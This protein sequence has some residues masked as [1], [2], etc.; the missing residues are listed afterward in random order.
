MEWIMR[1]QWFILIFFSLLFVLFLPYLSSGKITDM[2]VEKEEGPVDIEADELSYE[3]EKLIYEA[4]GKVEVKRGDL[5]LR[6]DHAQLNM[7]TKD[8]VAWGN[9]VLREGE[10]VLEAERLEINLDTRLGKVYQARLFLKDQNFH[11]TSKEAEKLGE[12]RY[13]IREGSFTTCDAARPAWKFTVKELEVTI[14]GYGIAKGPTFYLEGIPSLYLPWGFFPVKRERQT[15]LLL[16]RV[17]Y[18]ERY[19]P[20]MKNAFFWA[21]AKDMDFTVYLDYLGKRGFKEGLEYRYAFTQETRGQANFYFIDDQV[22]HK[23]RYAFFIQHQ[24]RFPYG[25]YLKSNINHVSDN[26]YHR[27]FDEDLFGE[28]KIDSRS[29][30]QLRSTLFGGRNWDRFSF[31]T[32][33]AVFQDLTKKSNDETV[34]KLPQVSFHAHPQSLFHTPLFFEGGASYSHFWREKGVEAHRGDFFPRLFFPIRLFNVLKLETGVG[35]RETI[36]KSFDDPTQKYKGWEFRETVVANTEVSTEFYRIYPA[37]KISGISRIF[38]VS[39]WMH[40][41]EPAISYQYSPRVNQKEIPQFDDMDRMAYVNQITYGFTQRLIGKPVKEGIHSGPSEYAKLKIFQS[42]SLGD[43]FSRDSKGRKRSF[44]NIQGELWWNFSPY[45][46]AKL[47]GELSPYHGNL[48]AG[49][50]SVQI[51]DNRNDVLFIQYRYAQ[52]SIKEVNAGAR[53]K[54]IPPLHLFGSMRYN[55]KDHWKVENIYGAEYQAQCW[56]LGLSA[57]DKGR[58]PDGTQ[59]RELKFQVYVNLLGLG[60][61]GKRSYFMGL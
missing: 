27:D 15:G 13:R 41:I 47:D 31:L 51:K 9:I 17:G 49:N 16:P 60:S 45:L 32:E 8:L 52:R 11:L 7:G 2:K 53:I 21:V 24:Q 28:A 14:E 30:G 56:T 39:K 18:S 22:F 4:H 44:S 54:T 20:E 19:G 55:M 5:Y 59:Q 33:A 12:N 40:T 50:A 23:N 57:E 1:A 36:Y 29:R 43:P 46:S 6:A 34:Q 26:R 48:E 38:K 35:P 61:L 58:S 25:F 37:E 10:D 42:Y 3:R